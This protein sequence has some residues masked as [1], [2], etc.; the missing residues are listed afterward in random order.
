MTGKLNTLLANN[1]RFYVVQENQVVL[2]HG[3]LFDGVNLNILDDL[4]KTN[5]VIDFSNVQYASWQALIAFHDYL[6]AMGK[7]ISIKNIPNAIY[8]SMKLIKDF[9]KFIRVGSFELRFIH[10]NEGSI[11]ISSRKVNIKRFPDIF[12][13][14]GHFASINDYFPLAT[15]WQMLPRNEYYDGILPKYEEYIV[16]KDFEIFVYSYLSFT[17]SN[18]HLANDI[19]RSVFI[20]VSSQLKRLVLSITSFIEAFKTFDLEVA[21]KP[22]KELEK[23]QKGVESYCTKE[24]ELLESTVHELE[25][26]LAEYQSDLLKGDP[27]SDKKLVMY[28]NKAVE[29]IMKCEGIPGT[30]DETGAIFG[31]V[32]FENNENEEIRNLVGKIDGSKVNSELLAKVRG[33][34]NIM[35][36]ISEDSWEETLEDIYEEINVL[37]NLFKQCVPL[38][39]GFDLT[40][41][42]VDHRLNEQKEIRKFLEAS[43]SDY[44]WSELRKTLINKVNSKLVTEQEKYS[45]AYYLKTELVDEKNS[46]LDPGLSAKSALFF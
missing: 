40:M 31:E 19:L 27:I 34:L 25:I 17:L 21:D 8:N 24:M 44:K 36:P 15:Q 9:D 39:Q 16:D 1:N 11:E 30:L 5:D 6:S 2:L 14:N 33:I 12:N 38:L 46:K 23:M 32:L 20:S 41:Q 42:V 22:V 10:Y 7:P 37:D 18:F 28:L 26:V 45:F 29:K 4:L 13:K 43:Q 3:V 35:N